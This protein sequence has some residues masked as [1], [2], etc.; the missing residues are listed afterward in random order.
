[1]EIP[2]EGKKR[3]V[4]FEGDEPMQ[5]FVYGTR[6]VD[7]TDD[8]YEHFFIERVDN[9]AILE[10]EHT[11]ALV[12]GEGTVWYLIIENRE[13]LS[14]ALS[15]LEREMAAWLGDEGVVFGDLVTE[16]LRND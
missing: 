15:E 8:P 7:T 4:I 5:G 16:D 3:F 14:Y 11:Q 9:A 13:Y 1:M 12:S 2:Y 10:I 6:T